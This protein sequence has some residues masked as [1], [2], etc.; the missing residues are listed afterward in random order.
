MSSQEV[1]KYKLDKAQLRNLYYPQISKDK[2]YI[3]YNQW[4][5]DF[6]NDC[7]PSV[8][9]D[10]CGVHYGSGILNKAVSKLIE[11]NG[12]EKWRHIIF[13]TAL[14]RLNSDS[15]FV[16]YGLQLYEEC[17]EAIEDSTLTNNSKLLEQDCENI[18][19]FFEEV[20][21]HLNSSQVNQ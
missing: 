11:T 3:E 15:H 6:P 9:N 2:Q 7:E 4:K 8:N 21:I 1:D 13:N 14:L 12:I 10:N 5:K 18:I 19:K 17:Y 20:G 16:D